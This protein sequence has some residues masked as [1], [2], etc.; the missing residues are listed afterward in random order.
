MGEEHVSESWLREYQR[1]GRFPERLIYDGHLR[2]LAD[3]HDPERRAAWECVIDYIPPPTTTRSIARLTRPLY[4]LL[5]WC[6]R[7]Q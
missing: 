1:P 7:P 4:L 5:A 2:E 3:F 6:R